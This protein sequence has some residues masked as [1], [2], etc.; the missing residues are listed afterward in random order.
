M[1]FK[2]F[3]LKKCYKW[4]CGFIL[5]IIVISIS[6]Y[7]RGE[8]IKKE[9]TEI[10]MQ[11]AE[12]IEEE[13]KN[14]ITKS[15]QIEMTFPKEEITLAIP[16]EYDGW[17]VIGKLEIPKINLTT[18]ILNTTTKENLNK[19]VTKLCGPSINRVGNFCITGHNYQKANMFS[20]LKRLEIGD[21]FTLTDLYG[22]SVIYRIYS[23]NQV[24]PGNIQCL[25][26]ETGGEREVTLITCTPGAL[27]RL[28]LKASEIY[29]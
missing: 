25:D 12:K 26:Q 15:E 7:E 11:Q 4:I 27:K 22:K 19:S 9:Q 5:I 3:Y 8:T 20:K 29:D 6:L 16:E 24:E 13:Q 1:H 2:V 21:K 10:L 28:I 17:T 18:Y 14:T 23:I